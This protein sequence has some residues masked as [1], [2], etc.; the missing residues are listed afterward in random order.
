MDPISGAERAVMV[1]TI[2]AEAPREHLTCT[3]PPAVVIRLLEVMTA[4]VAHLNNFTRTLR[5]G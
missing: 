2:M 4:D 3:L 5:S 1:P